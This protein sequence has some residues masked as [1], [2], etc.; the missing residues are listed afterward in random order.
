MNKF[1]FTFIAFFFLNNCSFNENSRIWKDKENK[2]ET[3]KK[4]TKVFVEENVNVSE[5]NRDLKL[6]LSSIKINNKKN[7]NLNNLGLLNYEGELTKIGNFKFSKL[8]ELNQLDFEPI[9]LNNGIIFFDKKGSIIRYDNNQKVIWKKN[10]YSKSE[11]KLKP[12]LNF[13]VDGQNL[14]VTDSI[15]KY[16][17]VNISTGEL[18]WSNNNDYPFNSNIKKHKDKIFVID[19]KNTLRCFKIKDGSEC[20]NLQTENSF[21]ISNIKYSLIILNDNVIFNNSI[22]DITAVDIETGL[23]TWQ[24][25]TQSSSII[26][27]TYNFKT[28]KLVSDGNS[29]FFS[30]NKNQFYSID[31]KTGT[32]NWINEVNSNVKPILVGNLIFTISNEGYLYL[33]DKNKGNI[34]RITDLFLNYKDKKR[35][36]IYPIGFVIGDKNIF[37]T[38][39]DGKMIIAG[40]ED[41]KII[42]IEKV[43]GG[44]VSEPFIFNNNLYVVRNGSI[45]QYN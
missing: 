11:K 17:S 38:N 7:D 37:L 31:L 5:F 42:K 9:F 2:L 35:K 41:G 19:Y 44:L 23:I 43:S 26:N 14:L 45:V 33:I 8:E 39:S 40:I 28:S 32:T 21:T 13:L 6:D 22:G 30:N 3:D 34:V 18:N 29:I 15:A 24:L 16:Y 4:I 25:P 27:E 12:K 20:W 1:I 36:N 10:H